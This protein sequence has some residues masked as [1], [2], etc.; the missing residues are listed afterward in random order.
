MTYQVKKRN[1]VEISEIENSKG[2]EKLWK[3]EGDADKIE[4]NLESIQTEIRICRKNHGKR[5]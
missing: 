5:N 4:K 1:G 2:K 3:N